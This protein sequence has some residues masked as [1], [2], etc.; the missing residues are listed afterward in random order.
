MQLKK[1]RR[2]KTPSVSKLVPKPYISPAEELEGTVA[3]KI[4]IIGCEQNLG[5]AEHSAEFWHDQ[6]MSSIP[7]FPRCD[8][9]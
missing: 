8:Y 4:C 7:E 1:K 2:N 3:L 5:L 6:S 9:G